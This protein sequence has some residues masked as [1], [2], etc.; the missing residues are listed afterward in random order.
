L[1]DHAWDKAANRH[2]VPERP[3]RSKPAVREA[4]RTALVKPAIVKGFGRLR[5]KASSAL[6]RLPTPP[7]SGREWRLLQVRFSNPDIQK[8]NL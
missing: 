1:K 5:K 6:G 3:L 8:A 7:G 4:A 2:S